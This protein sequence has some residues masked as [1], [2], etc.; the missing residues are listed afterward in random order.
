MHTHQSYVNELLSD[1]RLVDLVKLAKP[2]A[3]SAY[4]V[5]DILHPLLTRRMQISWTELVP[6]GSSWRESAQNLALLIRLLSDCED[7]TVGCIESTIARISIDASNRGLS[8]S[9]L[10]YRCVLFAEFR[11]PLADSLWHLGRAGC[12]ARLEYASNNLAQV[13]LVG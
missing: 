11:L 4:D 8:A 5:F 12:L 1:V 6:V 9:E 10:L 3:N 7:W 2:H 13:N